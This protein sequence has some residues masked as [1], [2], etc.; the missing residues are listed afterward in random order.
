MTPVIR[1][2]RTVWVKHNPKLDPWRRQIARQ[3]KLALLRQSQKK[4]QNWG[5]YR[6]PVMI[7]LSFGLRTP[8]RLHKL[9][10]G[11]LALVPHL[12]RFDVD[13]L[14]R[15]VLDALTGVLYCDDGQV[16]SLTVTKRYSRRPGV[17]I[18][19]AVDFDH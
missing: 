15:S 19:A 5:R 4:A 14:A 7:E 10:D 18:L 8:K 6:G 2:N 9:D 1:P 12:S 13:K 3:A 11:A 17:T 16:I